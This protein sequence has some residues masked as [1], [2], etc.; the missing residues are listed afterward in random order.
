MAFPGVRSSDS[1]LS[2]SLSLFL[3]VLLPDACPLFI[4]LNRRFLSSRSRLFSR[5]F[6]DLFL[7][8]VK[9]EETR[10]IVIS[11][12]V[13]RFSRILRH[14]IDEFLRGAVARDRGRFRASERSDAVEE[15]KKMASSRRAGPTV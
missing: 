13:A 4:L 11:Q 3:S 8:R 15:E 5:G 7:Q 2:L 10:R 14:K 9:E 1:S 6:V 12:R